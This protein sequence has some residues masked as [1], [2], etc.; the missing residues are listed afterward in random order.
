MG[1]N[2]VRY[3]LISTAKIG[4]N[5]HL[6]ASLKS[7][8]SEIVSISSRSASKAKAAAAE[9]GLRRWYA[10]YEDQLADP[11]IDAVI[12]PLPNSMHCEWTVKAAEEGKHI[13]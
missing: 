6:P 11:D 5:A 4:L 7:K 9:H 8:T 3:G 1:Q 2:V 12:N 13:L 10:S